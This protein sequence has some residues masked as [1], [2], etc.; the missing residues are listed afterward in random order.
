MDTRATRTRLSVLPVFI[1]LLFN[2]LLASPL[3]PVAPD[4]ALALAGSSFDATDGNMVV[5]GAEV[6]WCSPGLA[7]ASRID[8]PSGSSDNSFKASADPDPVPTIENG[9]IP[10]NKVDYDRVYATSEVN[11]VTGDLFAYVSFI[12][13]DTTGTG[14]LSF[15]LNQS[16]VLTSNG[17]TFERTQGDLLIEFNFQKSTDNWVVNLSYRVWNGDAT[18]GEWSDAIALGAPLAEGSVNAVDIV[19]CL[20]G[21]NPLVDGQFGEFAINLTDLL[22]GDCR[23]F[24][25]ILAKS[26]SS[27]QVTS[28]LNDLVLP[29]PV[30]FSTCG[31]I[32]ILKQ[33]ENQQAL[34]GATFSIS[35]NPFGEATDP[36]LVTD[37]LAP[38]DDATPGTIHLSDVEPGTY[39]VCETAA[40]AGYIIDPTCSTLTVA[41]NGS[42]TFGPFT[43][44]LGDIS[45]TKVDAQSGAL[46]CCA[47]FTLEGIAGAAAGVSLT[48]TDNDGV[49][50]ADGDPGEI[51]VNGLLL[52]TYTITETMPPSGY[53]LPADAS[54]DV[55]LSGE[56]ASAEFAFQDPPQADASI[57]KT[58]VLDPIVAGEDASFDITVAAGGTGDSENVVLT[59][60]NATGHTWTVTG[61][62]AADCGADL[63]IEDGDTLTCDFGTIANGDDRSITITMASDEGDCALGIANT[64]SVA[65]SNDH[66]SSNNEASDTITVLC[67]NPG[68]V[69]SAVVDPIV[70]GE[71]AS[72]TVTVTAGGTGGAENVVLTDV[73][74]TDH[75]WTVSGDDA[76]ACGADLEIEAGVTLI[77]NFGTIAEGDARTI[78][79]TMTSDAADCAEGIANTATIT[80]DADVDESNNESGDTIEVLCPDASV[81]KS[82]VLSPITAGDPASFTILVA[83]GGTGD[84]EGVVLTDVN[85]TSHTWTVSGADAGACGADLLIEAGDT[86]TCN[87]GTIAEGDDRTITITM[88][89]DAADCAEG[90]ANTATITADADVDP[91]NNE[92]SASIDVLCPDLEIEKSTD[93]P[94]VSADDEVHYTVTVSNETGAAEARDVTITDDLPNGLTWTEDSEDCVID[95]DGD[96]LC[97]DLTIPAGE[98]FSVTL[99][100]V[101]DSGDCPSIENTA[102]FTSSNGGNGSSDSDQRGATV[103]TVNCPDVTVDKEPVET[104]ISAGEF[105]QFTIAVTNDGPGLAK[106]VVVTDTAPA[107]TV[108]EVLDDGGASCESIV[109]GD[110]QSIICTVGDLADDA[111]VTITIQYLTTQEDC[112]PL[113]NLVSVVAS[114]EPAEN[115]ENNSDTATVIVECP[116]LNFV[117]TADADPI[118]AGDE[119][120]FTLTVWNNG[121][122]SGN[123]DALGVELHDDLPIGLAWD[124]E[125]V[126]GDAS[127]EDCMVASSLVLGGEQQMSIHCQF[128]TLA[129]T[130]MAGGIV[131]RVFADTDRT[132]CGLLENEAWADATNDDR[133]DQDASILV[134]CPTIGLEKAND[135]VGSVLPGTEVIYTL[136]LTVDDGPAKD[137]QVIDV[138]PVG[139]ENPHDISNGGTESPAGT[140]TWNL[141]D[142][143]DGEYTLTYRAVVADEVENG[144]ELVNVAS[145]TS[146]NSQCPDLETLGPECVDDSIVIV[147]V[148]TLVIDKVADTELITITGPNNALV[149][150]PSV[151]TW[152][153]TY[154]L[155]NGPVTNAVISDEVPVGFEF[156]DASAGGT[157]V[158]GVVTWTFDE[159]TE[160]GSVTFRTTVDPET[161]SRVAP[162]VNVAVI[163]S[164]QT[165][166]DEGQDSVTVTREEEL[167]GNPT[168]RPPLPN[169]AAGIGL[170]GEP[171]TVPIEL[172]A[173]FFIGSL[174]AL[175]LA[176]VK[177]RNRR[178]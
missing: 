174:G 26:R 10:N 141:G 128:G 14:T 54:Q 81:L 113:V 110:D 142:L 147:R 157:E 93:T 84:S 112:G 169:T 7:I 30:D 35:P 136:T 28:N 122:E 79:I 72:F 108:W 118:D 82:A 48:V 69:K 163:S 1:A 132:D 77:C 25:S 86:L 3:A 27:N 83:A 160:S 104:P 55:V 57:T 105:A 150:T 47:T 8:T 161:I 16:G 152:T 133:I 2:V 177:A 144:E 126:S 15:E 117:K 63:L 46:I 121:G 92:S 131:I 62:D 65:S 13:N 53:D 44:G 45:W 87:F 66:D 175:A 20:N 6:D 74:L 137:V 50:D 148:P 94:V 75:T 88:D 168:P 22:G 125:I 167:G 127:D 39:E 40:P 173:A 119:A 31:Q 91:S 176:N 76:A 89:S 111:S 101:T 143:A 138:L 109:G 36:L 96:L 170:N 135:A 99:T 164:D 9:S 95:L 158:D 29:I 166:E 19:D 73:N 18:D 153:L 123:A 149:A 139:L 171:I 114:N 115:T 100:G 124:F 56:T 107:G 103:I 154:T 129:P 5:D 43:N 85:E 64:A 37:D 98:S 52:G 51:Q 71:D 38:D 97:E 59:D 178:R 34:G 17:V 130:T 11:P 60:V 156:L 140:I 67:P 106:N 172:L 162:T 134:R 23:S 80:A 68:V 24:G 151:V 70:A 78:T 146:P 102:Q 120:S 165:P 41:N 145:A 42:A 4:A 58:A 32:T 155:A 90:I 61:D 159:L 33:D 21:N 12:R 116:G 49:Y